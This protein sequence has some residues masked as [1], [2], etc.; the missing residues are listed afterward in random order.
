MG[1][2][3]VSIRVLLAD[4]HEQFRTGVRRVL[5]RDPEFEVIAEA[6]SG[7]D[8]VRL[9]GEFRPD[10]A[11]IDVRMSPLNGIQAIPRILSR[12]PETAVLMLSMHADRSYVT[13]S[14]AAGARGYVLKESVGEVLP[15]AIRALQCG[16]LYF[17]PGIAECA[18]HQAP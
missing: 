14:V 18:P 17:S 7:A 10:V 5:E 13:R 1:A 8:A 3:C 15:E 2:D 16:K 4:D 12:S 6:E 9:A 11:V